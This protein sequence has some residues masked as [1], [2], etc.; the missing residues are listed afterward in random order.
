M[1]PFIKT[2]LKAYLYVWTVFYL[3]FLILVAL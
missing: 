1:W 2:G 3:I